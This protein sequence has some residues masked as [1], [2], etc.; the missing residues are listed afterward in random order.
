M[1]QIKLKE[2]SI[3]NFK[4]IENFVLSCENNAIIK[5]QN[6]SGKTTIYDAFSWLMTNKDSQGKADFQIKPV[7]ENGYEINHLDIE[8]QAILIVD[9]EEIKLKK[10]YKEL[11]TRKKGS[12]EKTF[13]GHRTDYFIDGSPEQKG[14]FEKFV[15]G[16]ID[17][18][19]I[20]IISNAF[21]FNDLN[22]QD[23]RQLLMDVCGD[24][25]DDEIIQNN[26]ALSEIPKI[27]GKNTVDQARKLIKTKKT[28]L[29]K[30]LDAIPIRI[31]ELHR[32]QELPVVDE[33]KYIQL[34]SDLES[35]QQKLNSIRN[36][37]K[38]IELRKN[39]GE[40]ELEIMEVKKA[41]PDVDEE[42]ME[43]NKAI[44]IMLSERD[45]I[46]NNINQC[47]NAISIK[48]N[49]IKN[50]KSEINDLRNQW[51]TENAKKFVFDDLCPTCKQPIP[52]DQKQKALENFNL[53]KS[54]SLTSINLEGKKKTEEIERTKSEIENT[55]TELQNHNG[56][57]KEIDKNIESKKAEI[58]KLKPQIDTGK[59]K[60]LEE[61]KANL[62]TELEFISKNKEVAESTIHAK[63]NEI[64]EKIQQIEID[65]ATI[66]AA[67]RVKKRVAELENE[68]KKLIKEYEK[69]EHQMHLL[70]QFVVA[71]VD[72]LT[73]KVNS[74]FKMA[75]FKLF[76]QNVNGGIE[77][78]CETLVN[79][80]PYNRG[81]NTG[82]RINCGL[83]II[84]KLNEY[85]QVCFPIFVDNSESVTDVIETNSQLICLAVDGG[86]EGLVIG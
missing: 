39:I 24:I 22:W 8:V 29:N 12:P 78:C 14:R 43:G 72:L 11:W 3:K 16:I 57:L 82:A 32:N 7:D 86:V 4:G 69:L 19:T 65:K 56:K 81:L 75:T 18:K 52:G 73:S 2:L 21:F 46:N 31:A 45:L 53:N 74:H 54:K 42:K 62:A 17:I 71:K 80:V 28:N 58:Q 59:I 9:Q 61:Q 84:N 79:G 1:K 77:P 55:K 47:K 33:K 60:K 64:S 37:T 6:G 13:S 30:E 48:E 76:K 83:D 27:L 85:Y 70:D 36:D 49:K 44:R 67:E 51:H 35:E 10:I 26:P 50:L 68:E 20:P 23:R 66:A 5:G 40:I 34:S 41:A 38:S 25:S 15:S 63:I